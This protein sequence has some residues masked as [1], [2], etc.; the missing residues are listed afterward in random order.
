MPTSPVTRPD[1]TRAAAVGLL[2]VLSGL[3]LWNAL[4]EVHGGGE[5]AAQQLATATQLGYAVLG[6]TAAVVLLGR[7]RPWVRPVLWAWAVLLTTTGGLAPRVWG[8]QGPG[9]ALAA[10]AATAVIAALA[11]WLAGRAAPGPAASRA[12]AIERRIVGFHQDELGDWVA[13]LECGHGQH[14]RH[15]P[16]WQVREWVVT[17]EGRARFLGTTLRCRRCVEES[18]RR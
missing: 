1:P 7:P 15:D 8:G 14:V 12:D 9:A 18:G 10:A 4:R 17:A 11:L 6:L 16:P 13:E 3:G 2:A 5:R